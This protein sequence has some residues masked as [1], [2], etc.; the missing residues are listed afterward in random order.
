MSIRRKSRRARIAG[1]TLIEALIATALMGVILTA[2]ATV[3]AQWL[4]NWNRGMGNVQR[5][6]NL[7]LGLERLTADVAA[8]EFIPG[9]REFLLPVF[10]GT[11]LSV[12]F[13]RSA[14][15]PNTRSGLELIRITEVGT[16]RGPN[17]VR[18][19]A[20]YAPVTQE[21]LKDQPNFTD[22]VVLVRSP[23]RISFAYAGRDRVWRNTWRGQSELPKAIRIQVRDATTDRLLSVST[24]T[25][26]HAEMPADC[27]LA[28]VLAD[29]LN[30]ERKNAGLT[31][32]PAP[33][34]NP[35]LPP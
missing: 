27:V 20:R 6:E 19:R 31:A 23:Y 24:S 28:E 30:R 4:P 16:D 32:T 12:T 7:A 1:F 26:V 15:G 18:A 34:P 13:V 5:A 14:L 17:L 8:A 25:L 33:N 11:E 29:C 3:T 35:R 9:G 22:P 21:T 2:I 10:D